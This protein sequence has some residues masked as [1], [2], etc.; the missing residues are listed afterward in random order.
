M[1]L[2]M[3]CLTQKLHMALSPEPGTGQ[4]VVGEHPSIRADK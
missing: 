3:L 2:L 1:D 4:N